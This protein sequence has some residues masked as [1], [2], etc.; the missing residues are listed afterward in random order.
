M[1]NRFEAHGD[2]QFIEIIMKNLLVA[3]IL[4]NLLLASC[5][6]TFEKKYQILQYYI[7]E[8]QDISYAGNPRMVYRLVLDVIQ[9]PSDE[10]IKYTVKE[11]WNS[12]NKNWKEF[13]V[14]VYLPEMYTGGVAYIIGEFNQQGLID[15]KKN[16][17][18][19]LGTKWEIK[20]MKD[21]EDKIQTADIKEYKIELSTIKIDQRKINININT[22]LP[23]GTNLLIDVRRSHFIKG[24]KEEYSGD[25]YSEDLTV[26]DGKIQTTVIINDIKWYNEYQE[27]S[28]SLPDD[29]P[30]IS[31]ISD[32]IKISVLFSPRRAQS[33]E[34]LEVLGENGEY[35]KGDGADNSLSFTTFRVSKELNIPFKK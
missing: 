4:G 31:S 17:K 24:K 6:S 26:R 32:N 20:E 9:L 18:A 1:F 10:H 34:T 3:I 13:T 28:E 16:E 27:L 23:N 29:F 35:I 12:G 19:L 21:T 14:F 33:K 7:V 11:V 8:K 2:K 15:F 22:D 30:P 5:Q 25:I